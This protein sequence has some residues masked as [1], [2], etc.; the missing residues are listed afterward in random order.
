MNQPLWFW[1]HGYPERWASEVDAEMI[2]RSVEQ[3]EDLDDEDV[4]YLESLD[5]EGEE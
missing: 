5:E 4:A 1:E 3:R 2:A